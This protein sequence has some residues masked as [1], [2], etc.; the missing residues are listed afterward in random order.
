[1]VGRGRFALCV[2]TLLWAC[3]SVAVGADRPAPPQAE[4]T[5]D[6]SA[7]DRST[8]TSGAARPNCSASAPELFGDFL[9]RFATD[10]TFAAERTAFPL[11]AGRWEYGLGE[12]GSDVSAPV[13]RW[14]SKE[15][16]RGWT[17][18]AS[19]QQTGDMSVRSAASSDDSVQVTLFQ[20]DSDT[21][22]TYTFNR[23]AGCWRLVEFLDKSL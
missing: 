1:M 13:W 12:Q 20:N 17:T 4:P 18:I 5:G 2:A 3:M 6:I 8:S 14:I 15:A 22:M 19:L 21:E 7:G 23:Q 11:R 16:F 10:Q 9:K